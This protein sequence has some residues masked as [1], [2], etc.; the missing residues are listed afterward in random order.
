MMIEKSTKLLTEREAAEEYFGWSIE[1]M[2][3][4]RKRGEIEYFKFN[5]QVIKYSIEQL[6]NY[7][8]RFLTQAS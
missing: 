1:K 7:K 8:N 5:E 3:Q 4:I 6:E 2:R